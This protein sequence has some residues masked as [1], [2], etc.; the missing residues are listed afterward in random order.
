M[1]IARAKPLLQLQT[2]R[3]RCSKSPC[4]VFSFLTYSDV[5]HKKSP[6]QETRMRDRFNLYA[7]GGDGGN[8]STSF[9]RSRHDRRGKPDGGN[10]GRGG[11]VILE[12]STAVWDFSGLQNHVN[13]GRGGHGTSKNKIGTRGEDKILQ[14]PIGTVIHLKKGEI[15]SM[16][17]HCSSADLDPWE[18][19]GSLSTDQ[20]EVDQLPSSKNTSMTEKVKSTHVAGHLS[21]CTETTVDQSIGMNQAIRPQSEPTEEIRYNVAELTEEGQRMIVAYGGEGGLGNVCYPNVSM[22]PKM[23]KGEVPRVNSIEDEASNDD[24]SS[25]RTGLLGSEAVLVLELK[26]IADVGLV[27]M[28]NAGKSTLL[29]AISRAKPAVGHYAFTTLRPNLGNL[30]FDDLSITVADIPG[31]IKGAHQNRGLGHAFLCH[32]ERTKVL[33][34][35]VDLAA[36][37][38]GRKGIPPWEQLKDL[39]LELEHHQEGLSNRPSLVVANKIDETGA[40]D[41]FQELEKRVEGIPIYRVCAVLEEGISE[42]KAGLKMLVNGDENSSSLNIE[43]IR[44]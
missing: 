23:T 33:A 21:S 34:Y 22:K 16:V 27:G 44:C 19:P 15:P 32:I 37:L 12:C 43:N 30:N 35:V 28:P 24:R 17:E 3:R 39:V 2:I 40:E 10:G 7:K 20:S 29:G 9:R 13:A 11:D 31:L 38:D 18:L 42:V 25:L 5:P 36:A 14:V 41:V 6:L 26:S 4:Y 8:G 1:W